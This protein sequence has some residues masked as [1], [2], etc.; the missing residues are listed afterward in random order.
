M[1]RGSRLL[2]ASWTFSVANGLSSPV[3]G[4]YLFTGGSMEVSVEFYIV[5]AAFIL[6][7]Y[8]AVGMSSGRLRSTAS[9][10]RPGLALLAA[11]YFTLLALGPRA[12]SCV[13]P[14][15]A[16][17][18]VASGLYWSGWDIAYYEFISD[19]LTFFNRLSYLGFASSLALP[20]IY[21]GV[22]AALRSSGYYVLFASS[23]VGLA[24]ASALMP[25][26]R[27]SLGSF[28]VLH[29]ASL[30]ARDRRYGGL[31]TALSM[32][33]GYGYSTS[34]VN[35][36]LT[37]VYFG[38]SY[39]RFAE[40]NYAL[41]VLGVAVV[42]ARR[43][44]ASRLGAGNLVLYSSAAL[45]ASAAATAVTW[46]AAPAYLV[47][48]SF[49]GQMVTFVDVETWN[50]MR[51]DRFAEYMTNR[52]LMLNTGR[53]TASLLVLAVVNFL[54]PFTSP[55]VPGAFALAGGSYFKVIRRDKP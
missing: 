48:S 23:A 14:L 38:D 13:P 51:H 39:S 35:P 9:L 2:W 55:L 52:H 29:M 53:V 30:P 47:A 22:L 21:G 42:R 46:R 25:S 1:D 5:S 3:L 20:A 49:M 11:F 34:Y 50:S 16:L 43:W 41:N 15:A 32:L 28:S 54:G 27:P 40:F 24:V 19:R 12:H 17:Y 36:I 31:V 33:F 18:G 8:I 4:L 7:T 6:A 26:L 44:M 45:M 37:Y 10:Y